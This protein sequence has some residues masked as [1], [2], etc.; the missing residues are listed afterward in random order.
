MKLSVALCDQFSFDY[1]A[2]FARRNV[3]L[4]K[5]LKTAPEWEKTV[6]QKCGLDINVNNELPLGEQLLGCKIFVDIIAKLKADYQEKIDKVQKTCTENIQT[7]EKEIA[8][9]KK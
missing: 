6:Y 8:E 3:M 9:L 7:L 4:V 1:D 5:W 2:W